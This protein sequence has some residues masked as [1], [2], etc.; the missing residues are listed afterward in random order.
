MKVTDQPILF[1]LAG[2]AVCGFL[3]VLIRRRIVNRWTR[4]ISGV[5]GVCGL[6]LAALFVTWGIWLG[7][8]N[9][10]P[11][12]RTLASNLE[13]ERLRVGESG[14]GHLVTI[15]LDDPC[16]LLVTT[17]LEP[18]GDVQALHTETW[19]REQDTQIA[20]NASFFGPFRDF[21]PWDVYPQEGELVRTLGGS[22]VDG[23]VRAMPRDWQ[24][25]WAGENVFLTS[26]GVPGIAF[27]APKNAIWGVS[28][29]ERILDDGVV[30]ASVSEPYPRSIVAVDASTNTMWWLV[31]DGKQAGYS[32]GATLKETA[33]LLQQM[34]ATDALEMD[35]GGSSILVDGTSGSQRV[36][37]RPFNQFMPDRSRVVANHIG[38][39][40]GCA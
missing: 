32:S 35:G 34:G 4:R 12:N 28:G 21:P 8:G 16:T 6:T 26:D 15:D 17:E 38:V 1:G 24:G 36:L 27:D 11:T 31:V 3:I 2:F 40:D 25:M 39:V 37:S 13:Y 33:E 29:R 14:V 30:T 7:L 20:M 10:S 19:A 9:S 23:N 18:S 5:F 22:V